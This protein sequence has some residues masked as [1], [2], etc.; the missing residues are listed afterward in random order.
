MKYKDILMMKGGLDFNN[1]VNVHAI[2][3]K[4]NIYKILLFSWLNE[5][6]TEVE[7]L[8][9]ANMSECLRNRRV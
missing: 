3:L 7:T 6:H 4:M 1:L 2:I 8:R 9:L 5:Y